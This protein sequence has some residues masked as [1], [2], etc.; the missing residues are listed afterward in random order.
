MTD[1]EAK[2]SRPQPLAAAQQAA[3]LPPPA[4][5]TDVASAGD[6][7]QR[8]RQLQEALAARELQLERKSD[9]VSQVQA[10]CDQLQVLPACW[11]IACRMTACLWFANN[12]WWPRH[13]Y[14]MCLALFFMILQYH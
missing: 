9:E 3:L 6:L 11:Y 5:S 8:L 7:E 13:P 10:V 4:F 12:R 2:Q 14:V 1:L